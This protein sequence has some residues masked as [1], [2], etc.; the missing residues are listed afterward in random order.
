MCVRARRREGRGEE[1]PPEPSLLQEV[2]P[3]LTAVVPA[4]RT[5]V[6][7][8]STEHAQHGSPRHTQAAWAEAFQE[9]DGVNRPKTHIAV[10]GTSAKHTAW[11]TCL[12]REKEEGRPG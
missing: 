11:F 5:C 4:A 3:T 8:L 2:T 7:C 10:R 6:L 9:E 12:H 1:A